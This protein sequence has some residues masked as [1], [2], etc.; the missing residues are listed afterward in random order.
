VC[1]R[2]LVRIHNILVLLSSGKVRME[3]IKKGGN[4][5]L[6]NDNRELLR[7]CKGRC[8]IAFHVEIK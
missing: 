2:M 6:Q 8:I 7:F 1:D 4:G 5:Y 3:R